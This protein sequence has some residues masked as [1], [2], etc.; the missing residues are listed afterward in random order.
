MAR[1]NSF[2]N[3]G[4]T[5]V[6]IGGG[7]MPPTKVYRSTM[8]LKEEYGLQVLSRL[9]GG[10]EDSLV[11]TMGVRICYSVS[12]IGSPTRWVITPEGQVCPPQGVPNFQTQSLADIINT[13]GH[14]FIRTD[15][16]PPPEDPNTFYRE[17]MTGDSRI[18]FLH[19]NLSEELGARTWADLISRFRDMGCGRCV[20]QH[21]RS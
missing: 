16:A 17:F 5:G 19:N 1:I 6:Y 3:P 4:C 8:D 9:S 15:T 21:W 12:I 18:T 10:W 13:A 20:R 2:V 14:C 7:E 11:N